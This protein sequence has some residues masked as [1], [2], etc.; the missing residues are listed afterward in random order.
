MS[1]N[2][3]SLFSM[4]FTVNPHLWSADP[5]ATFPSAGETFHSSLKGG[6]AYLSMRVLKSLIILI[7]F[8]LI[9]SSPSFNS[10]IR[11]S[12]LLMKSTGLTPSCNACL[13][14]VSDWVI[15]SSTAS[16]TTT[17]PST[18]LNARVTFPLKSKCP[19]VSTRFIRKGS[20]SSR[21]F[22]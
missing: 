3:K 13:M 9:S 15:I 17:T 11:R 20:C 21:I 10:L 7:Y 1:L 22:S 5:N 6:S 16:T 4:I 12:T 18:S 8:F 14:T 2:F 19:G